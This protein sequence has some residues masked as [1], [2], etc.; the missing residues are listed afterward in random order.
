M[1]FHSNMG[2]DIYWSEIMLSILFPFHPPGPESQPSHYLP[3]LART[4][5]PTGFVSPVQKIKVM[6]G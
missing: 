2:N 6:K 3:L 5:V 1:K 4:T